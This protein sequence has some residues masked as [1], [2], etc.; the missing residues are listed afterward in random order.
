MFTHI[1]KII[2]CYLQICKLYIECY[3]KIAWVMTKSKYRI[4]ILS[5]KL[6]LEYLF[7]W[8]SILINHIQMGYLQLQIWMIRLYVCIR[9]LIPI[10]EPMQQM[11]III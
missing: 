4:S 9:R 1:F 6:G 3:S 11:N 8:S 2:Y 7:L 10:Q 5:I